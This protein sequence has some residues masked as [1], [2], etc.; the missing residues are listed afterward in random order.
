VAPGQ[1]KPY[2][3]RALMA[4]GSKR[5]LQW[6][7]HAWSCRLPRCTRSVVWRRAVESLGTVAVQDEW[8]IVLALHCS[9]IVAAYL[10][11]LQALTALLV[12]TSYRPMMALTS[13]ALET[14][15]R[16]LRTC[17]PSCTDRPARFSLC[18]RPT[19]HKEPSDMWHRRSPPQP[20]GEVQSHRTR[21]STGVHLS[22]EA[23]SRAIGT[24]AAPEPTLG[25]R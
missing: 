25:W 23:R 17:V 18:L 21:G 5:C 19:A 2:G 20:R 8:S 24:V 13:G 22:R 10:H 12:R 7:G 6:H 11:A 16:A 3:G 14:C 1:V 15:A 4:R 9:R